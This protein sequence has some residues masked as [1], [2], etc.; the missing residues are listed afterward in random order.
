M[1]RVNI[2]I[3]REKEKLRKIYLRE[4]ENL[5]TDFKKQEEISD[6]F[7]FILPLITCAALVGLNPNAKCG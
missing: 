6:L 3:S 5:S 2:E 4:N 1:K 7:I